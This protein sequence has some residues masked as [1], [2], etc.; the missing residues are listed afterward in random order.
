M[1]VRLS[2]FAVTEYL[3]IQECNAH[4]LYWKL[5]KYSEAFLQ[6]FCECVVIFLTVFV[7]FYPFVYH[8][9]TFLNGRVTISVI[10]SVSHGAGG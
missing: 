8:V 7:F 3:A 2:K 4:V 5:H 6:Y 10:R 9:D 1:Q